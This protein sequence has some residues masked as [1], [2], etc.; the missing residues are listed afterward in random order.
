[1][2]TVEGLCSLR[3]LAWTIYL[4]TFWWVF[5]LD[6]LGVRTPWICC[7]ALI[8]VSGGGWFISQVLDAGVGDGNEGEI[9]ALL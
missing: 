2:H 6:L 3:L 4:G 5:G 9:T 1:M 8:G 7:A